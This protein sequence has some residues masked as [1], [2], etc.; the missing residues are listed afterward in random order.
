VPITSLA[1]PT[2]VAAF[3]QFLQSGQEEFPFQSGGRAFLASFTNFP[4]SFGNRWRVGV[5]V[6]EEDFTAE[7]DHLT[8][9]VMIICLAFLALALGLAVWL[10]RLIS[11]PVLQLAAETDQIRKLELAT[12]VRLRS[13]ITEIQVLTQAVERMKATL[14]SFLRFA[15]RQLVQEIILADTELLLGG[16][17]REVTLLFSDL[18]SFTQFAEQ[19][20][21]EEVVQVLNRHFEA[22]VCIITQYQGYTVD[23][24]GDSLFAAFGALH[25]DPEHAQHAVACAVAMQLTQQQLNAEAG[26]QHLPA[27]EMGIGINSGTCVVGNM[28]SLERIKYDVVGHA[29]NV[30]ARIETFTVGGQI[31]ISEAT[32]QA[33]NGGVVLAGPYQAFGKGVEGPLQVYEVRG[34][35][36]PFEVTVP[37]TVPDLR[38]VQPPLAIHLRLITGKQVA[39]G[40]HPATLT[41]L[42]Q[43]GAAFTTAAPLENFAPVQVGLPECSGGELFLDG[44]VVAS[45]AAGQDYLVKFSPLSP[46]AAALIDRLLSGGQDSPAGSGP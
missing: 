1:N 24:L 17:R 40:L 16:E 42:G 30:A 22:M 25:P 46:A 29:V 36:A 28:G 4:A 20:R 23:F 37:P 9:R 10:A 19:N 8:R 39:T 34:L 21:P 15:P 6:P 35:T 38:P 13:H 26:E 31:L 12:T 32:R 41:R 43:T 3:Q 2:V 33:L 11:K 27:L 5:I 14:R 45:N 7:V 18:R 44:K